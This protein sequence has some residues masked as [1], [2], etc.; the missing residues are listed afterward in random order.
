LVVEYRRDYVRVGVASAWYEDLTADG[1]ADAVVLV[2][3]DSSALD[4]GA[5]V[6]NWDYV[7]LP[8]GLTAYSVGA[9]GDTVAIVLVD[10]GFAP[11]GTDTL[12]VEEG[13]ALA[14]DGFLTGGAYPVDDRVAPAIISATYTPGESRER[15]GKGDTLTVTFTEPAELV[16]GST[17]PFVLIQPG[18]GTG[19]SLRLRVAVTDGAMVR[20][21]VDSISGVS[22]PAEGDLIW[23]RA[24]GTGHVRDGYGNVQADTA[25]TPVRLTVEYPEFSWSAGAVGGRFVPLV[26][27]V[28]ADLREHLGIP[29]V[30][31]IVI[32]ASPVVQAPDRVYRMEGT[33][34]VYDV[35]GNLVVR[36]RDLEE[37]PQTNHLYFVW[38]GRNENGRVVGAGTYAAILQGSF[39][40]QAP[41]ARWISIGVVR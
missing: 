3:D 21:V 28:P 32:L 39:G 10:T 37:A 34:A 7:T 5:I 30:R 38:D 14:V 22:Y 25:N 33:V 41:E 23:I 40:D 16:E 15:S 9:F 12:R 17:E 27:R 36:E 19:Y 29:E 13:A 35:V 2:V 8:R 26:T 4:I 20:F 18:T 24:T 31:G 11:V 1:Y 6:D